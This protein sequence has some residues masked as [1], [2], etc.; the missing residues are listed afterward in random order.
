MDLVTFVQNVSTGVMA[1]LINDYTG[2]ILHLLQDVDTGLRAAEAGVTLSLEEMA[3]AMRL[4]RESS[5]IDKE[6]VL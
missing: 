5:V 1:D 2:G 6:F 3:S 4:F